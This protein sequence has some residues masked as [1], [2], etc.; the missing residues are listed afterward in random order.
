MVLLLTRNDLESFLTMKDVME[1]VEEGFRQ[2]AIGNVEMP[3]RSVVR[4][5]KY[6]GMMVYM[7][8]YISGMDALAVKIVSVYPNNPTNYNLPTVSGTVLLSDPKT[9]TLLSIMDGAFITSMRTGAVG[10]VA[11]KYL[12]RKDSKV[13][14]IFGCGVQARTQLIALSETRRL[15]KAKAYDVIPENSKRFCD[16]MST[17]VDF[18]IV[19]TDDPEEVVKG[20]DII[21]TATTSKEP[22]FKG[23]WLENGTHING[24][25]SHHGPG[26][27]ELDE[28]TIKKAKVVVDSKEACLKEAGDLIDPISMGLISKHHIH[29]ELG[30]IILGKK[31]ARTSDDEITLFKSVGLALQDAATAIKAYKMA[32]QFGI[33]Q[34]VTV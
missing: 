2:Y 8:A 17:H 9:G 23:E 33:G 25:G 22:V 14:G 6:G 34:N 19:P 32:K 30:E 20:S 27:R 12:A 16:E 1:A 4:V 5:E 18:E 13:A 31:E 11:A 26:I 10:G 15:E 24:I 28:T 7:P 21:V 29:A 3:I